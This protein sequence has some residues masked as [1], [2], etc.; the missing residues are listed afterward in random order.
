MED[1][2]YYCCLEGDWNDPIKEKIQIYINNI[3]MENYFGLH[4]KQFILFK[5]IE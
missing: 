2:E 4:E 3:T 1:I 5:K